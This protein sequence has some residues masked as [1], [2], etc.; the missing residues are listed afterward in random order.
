L[1]SALLAAVPASGSAVPTSAHAAHPAGGAAAKAS[2]AAVA[3]ARR[4]TPVRLITGDEVLLGRSG[5]RPS[6]A[7]KLRSRHG[8]AGQT[9]TIV[10]N[11]DVYVIPGAARRYLGTLLDP[12]LFDVTR[13]AQHTTSAGPTSAGR[14]PVA[15]TVRRGARPTVPGLTVVSR[16]RG[17][18]RGYLTARGSR[19]FGAALAAQ[20]RADVHRNR[21]PRSL[22]GGVTG[23]AAPG[24]RPARPQFQQY[25][26]KIRVI[27][28]AGAPA[29]DAFVS[30]TDVDDGRK[31]T[32]FLDVNHGLAKV[33]VPAGTYSGLAE[34]DTFTRSGVSSYLV[35]LEQISVT[36]N[37]A[38]MTFDTRTATSIPSVQTPRPAGLESEDLEWDR[39]TKHAELSVGDGFSTGSRVHVAPSGPAT[40][41]RLDWLV[42]WQLASNPGAN[43][44]NT[45]YS[46]DLAFHDSDAVPA[47]QTHTVTTQDLAQV[48]SRYYTDQQARLAYFGRGAAF[49]FQFFV[50]TELVALQTP[51]ARSEYVNTPAGARWSATLFAAP[52]DN[53]PFEG[54]VEDEDRAYQPG[55]SVAEDWLRGPL[56]PGMQEPVPGGSFFCGYCRGPKQMSLFFAPF[57]DTTPG[58]AGSLDQLYPGLPVGHF[59]LYRDGAKV[60]AH[61]NR[62]GGQ[63]R[64]PTGQATYRAVVRTFR[65]FGGFATSTGA[66]EN[67]RFV[68]SAASGA[69][70]PPRWYCAAAHPK[71][72]T[73]LPLLT[74]SVPLPTDLE[75]T[76][77]LGSN[78]VTFTVRHL[79]GAADP[80]VKHVTFAVTGNEGRTFRSLPVTSL[81][82]NQYQVTIKNRPAWANHGVGIRVG[83]KDAA[84]GALTETVADAYFVASS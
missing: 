46:Y 58:H 81:G 48:Q 30:L 15:L 33:S 54:A 64:V 63:F 27:N 74:A 67:V 50:E 22:F 19:A 28:P 5:N 47:D 38:A 8:I 31:F 53:D 76:M 78:T 62:T 14:I 23:I 84:G 49:P 80:T 26:L 59:A 40:E 2:A 52:S 66:S 21:T 7:T 3:S 41:G 29:N 56:A 25:T 13:L 60:Y 24:A 4:V 43:G 79:S 37:N 9:T 35:P 45:P 69:A 18:E 61:R 51:T 17:S 73:V 70:R 75:G 44:A 57:V 34:Y 55:T 32:N 10:R 36:Q 39:S 82:A 72:C 77:P 11:G 20:W 12:S 16:S 71:A 83:A 68:S 42:E 1:S 65:G 6:V